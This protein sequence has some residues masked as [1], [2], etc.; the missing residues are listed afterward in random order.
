MQCELIQ[1]D[2][3]QGTLTALHLP[4]V[5][6][7]YPSRPVDHGNN[8]SKVLTQPQLMFSSQITIFERR[9][10]VLGIGNKSNCIFVFRLE[11]LR[12]NDI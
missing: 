6:R 1:I 2:T 11:L 7:F 3:Y 10:L 8:P 9:E 12:K 4:H 5:G